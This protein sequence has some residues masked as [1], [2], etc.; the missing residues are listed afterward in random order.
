MPVRRGRNAGT[1]V[2]YALPLYPTFIR[3]ESCIL[4]KAPPEL[5]G[6]PDLHQAAQMSD[7]RKL[8]SPNH[9]LPRAYRT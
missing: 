3:S 7:Q 6:E 2:C 8:F 1:L 9:S 5:L 4:C